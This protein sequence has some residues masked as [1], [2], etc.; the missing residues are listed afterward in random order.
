MKC[1]KREHWYALNDEDIKMVFEYEALGKG[2]YW[3]E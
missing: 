3:Q 2:N 1:M